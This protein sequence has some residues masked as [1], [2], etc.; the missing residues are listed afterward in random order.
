LYNFYL[1]N[2]SY[3]DEIVDYTLKINGNKEQ[4]IEEK[5]KLPTK[6]ILDNLIKIM[7]I[8]LKNYL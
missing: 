3:F 8:F 5:N 2:K 1:N 6:E 4:I 7:N